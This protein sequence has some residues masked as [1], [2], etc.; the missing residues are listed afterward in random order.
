[1][2]MGA[3]IPA[4]SDGLMREPGSDRRTPNVRRSQLGIEGKAKIL[5][6]A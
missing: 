6:G 3:E 5:E 2:R 1:M 4:A